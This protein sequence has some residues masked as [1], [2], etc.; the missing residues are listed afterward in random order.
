MAGGTLF[1][2][3]IVWNLDVD[4]S[5]LDEGL[6][7][8]SKKVKQFGDTVEK[9]F[10]QRQAESFRDFA[11]SVSIAGAGIGVFLKTAVDASNK[12]QNAFAGLA[13]ATRAFNVDAFAARQAAMSL[14]KDGLISVSTAAQS[15]ESLFNGG[16]GLPD[17]IKLIQNY[18]D[19]A[20]F[21]KNATLSMNDAVTN[22]AQ[23]F[24]TENSAIGNASGQSENYSQIVDRGARI[25][26][27]SADALSDRERVQAKVIGTQQLGLIVE[28]NASRLSETFA[29]KQARLGT[30]FFNLKS[31]IG[32]VLKVG[33]TP[34]T[35]KLT[36]LVNSSP[37]VTTS[38]VIA[39]SGAVAFGVAL[40]TLVGALRLAV[41]ILAGP[42]NLLLTGL[43]ILMGVTVFKAVQSLQKKMA[44]TA[45][46]FT[47]GAKNI[48]TV[49]KEQLGG[50]A[51]K[52]ASDLSEKLAEL[53]EEIAR[54]NKD[55][56]ENLA[57]M[58]R[59][60]QSKVA[61]LN[62][63]LNLENS[64]FDA[65]LA[66]RKRSLAQSNQE[67]VRDHQRR[68][69]QIKQQIQEET[70]SDT[71][72]NAAR[73]KNLQ[74]R[75]S[76]E[77]AKGL[78]ADQ[79][80]ISS[81]QARLQAERIIAAKGNQGKIA[82]LQKT[83]AQENTDFQ[84]SQKKRLEEYNRD[85]AAAEE[86]HQRKVADTTLELSQQTN[87]L[88]AHAQEVSDVQG[89]QFRD[90]IQK[91]KDAHVAQLAEYDKQKNQAIKKAA[92]TSSGIAGAFNG[93]GGQVNTSSFKGVGEALGTDF[94]QGI[95]DALKA[96]AADT[97]KSVVDFLKGI[98][99]VENQKNAANLIENKLSPIGNSIKN[100]LDRFDASSKNGFGL[101]GRAM[102]GPVRA[103]TPYIVGEK[104]PE[105]FIPDQ[106]GRIIPD[107][108]AMGQ[109]SG[110][111]STVT[112]INLTANLSGIVTRSRA[113][114][115]EVAV[116]LIS[117]VNEDL[118][119]RG[120]EELGGGNLSARSTYV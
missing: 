13:S 99:S 43:S 30:A 35:E 57:E 38:F 108:S 20:A 8:A 119:A 58:V 18:K 54:S 44:D 23:S 28:G 100:L 45:Q 85:V 69:E 21:G 74:D 73:I 14:S 78:E 76:N 98:F 75:L 83:L 61:K 105:L 51:T 97:G 118:R 19:Q 5:R 77:R 48:G 70:R 87:L 116:D 106:N 16:V 50:K 55:F 12:T 59:D 96:A 89:F 82:E 111:S 113:E 2:G 84:E 52:A 63:E 27:K 109:S 60:A 32:D 37:Q 72:A 104:R 4:P 34:L 95:K 65:N 49:A 120:L 79:K 117:A 17:A 81:L 33:L 15:L 22:L 91:L 9:S 94:A 86:A 114:L 11:R 47:S 39:A 101:P 10:G 26:G 56:K 66:E 29:G 103:G 107:L 68:V 71:T 90:E 40:V 42:F 31:Q 24:I 67:A 41:T 25:L 62:Q 92:E 80:A 110:S 1:G 46:T 64:D 6:D 36:N 115:R 3:R 7:S 93:I 112:N 88:K 53:D 102:G